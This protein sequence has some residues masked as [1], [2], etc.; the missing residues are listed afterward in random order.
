MPALMI[1]VIDYIY[2]CLSFKLFFIYFICNI[3]RPFLDN[4]FI[5]LSSFHLATAELATSPKHGKWQITTRWSRELYTEHFLQLQNTLRPNKITKL[6]DNYTKIKLYM[7]ASQLQKTKPILQA[8]NQVTGLMKPRKSCRIRSSDSNAN[9][10]QIPQSEFNACCLTWE[11]E[12]PFVPLERQHPWREMRHKEQEFP[13]ASSLTHVKAR[14]LC[15]VTSLQMG[16]GEGG[17]FPAQPQKVSQE[18]S[19]L[20]GEDSNTRTYCC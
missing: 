4:H 6:T 3:S 12:Q 16:L 7:E 18:S 20:S 9:P 5:P 2:P 19:F 15:Q 10:Q 8:V 17:A 14:E 1:S 11:Q 13:P